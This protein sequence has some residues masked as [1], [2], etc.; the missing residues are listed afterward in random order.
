MEKV[1]T[2]VTLLSGS[3]KVYTCYKLHNTVLDGSLYKGLYGCAYVRACVPVCACV[4]ARVRACARACACVRACVRA[5]V[6]LWWCSCCWPLLYSAVLRSR[7][8]SLRS[9]VVLHEWTQLFIARFWISTV[10]GVL[11]WETASM[12][13]VCAPGTVKRQLVWK[14]VS[15]TY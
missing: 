5:C 10:S 14:F 6:C 7:A 13:A 3:R 8:D 11:V 15:T 1:C 12:Y 9:H 2:I 4:R